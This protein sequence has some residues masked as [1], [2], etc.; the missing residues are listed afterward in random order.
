MSK[1][2]IYGILIGLS[3][4][5]VVWL[6]LGFKASATQVY[7]KT[8]C[9]HTPGNQVTLTFHTIQAYFG[10]LGQP[11]SGSTFDTNGV[12]Q[13]VTPTPT[14][15]E[16]PTPTPTIVEC[17]KDCEEVTPTPTPVVEGSKGDDRGDYHPSAVEAPKPPTCTIEFEAPK[18]WYTKLNGKTV[19]NW[20]TDAQDIQKFSV[21]YGY[22]EDNLEYGVDNIS[23]NVRSLEVSG[24][25]HSPVFFQVW[26]W[27]HDC[28]EKS[29]I[30]DP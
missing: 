9:H 28:A 25:T 15:T 17:E 22:K 7:S 11:H 19:F 14:P 29:E 10:H 2:F 26:S 20:A 12:C 1:T 18:V 21:V 13:E 4:L 27:A 16:E 5:V 24:L 3:L 30:V 23:A 8:I 6:L